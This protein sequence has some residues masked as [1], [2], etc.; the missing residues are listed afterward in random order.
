V[1]ADKLRIQGQKLEIWFTVPNFQF[2][3]LPSEVQI[4][5]LVLG[6][7]DVQALPFSMAGIG[8]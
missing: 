1:L 8:F 5:L 4:Q 6:A 2:F 7:D 3:P